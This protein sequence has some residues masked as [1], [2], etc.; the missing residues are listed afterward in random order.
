M[1]SQHRW[2]AEKERRLIEMFRCEYALEEMA[3]EL[4]LPVDMIEERLAELMQDPE[5]PGASPVRR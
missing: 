2:D 3:K 1:D 5:E 4:S